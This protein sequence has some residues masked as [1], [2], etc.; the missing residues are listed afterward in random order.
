MN[1]SHTVTWQRKIYRLTPHK[2]GWR[3]RSRS[4][5][6]LLDLTFPSCSITSAKRQAMEH[7]E[8]EQRILS[9]GDK[10]TLEEVIAVYRQM[11]KKA[12]EAAAYINECRL[13]AIIRLTLKRELRDVIVSEVTPKLWL[14]FMALKLGGKID[15]ARRRPGNAAI[16][17]AVRC[18]S[19][20]FIDR[21]RPGFAALGVTI[22]ADAT[23]IQ[24]LPVMQRPQP[25]ARPELVEIWGAMEK[26]PLYWTIG[27]ARFAGLRRHEIAACRRTW[28]VED[29]SGVYVEL[30]DRPEEDFTHKTGEM[31]R[32]RITCQTFAAELLALPK[33]QVVRDTPAGMTRDYWFRYY[34]QEWLEP[35]TGTARKR[36]HRL[37]GLYADDVKRLTQDAVT[38]HLAGIK[39]ASANLGHTNTQT[40]QRSYLS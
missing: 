16:N 12:G 31:Y 36:L 39:A 33:G 4:R 29:A 8:G 5:G 26:G 19:S 28:I 9:R 1:D 40:T 15:L 17:S 37:R 23:N 35:F 32:A 25:E 3:I 38:A 14:D 11:P 13:R 6:N 34:P 27:L 7:F 21:L 2:A 10:A 18:A 30:R 20:I 22:P 24:W